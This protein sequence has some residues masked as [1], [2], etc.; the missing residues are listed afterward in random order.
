[1][2]LNIIR[3]M[4][5]KITMKLSPPTPSIKIAIIKKTKK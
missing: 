5:I 4:Q 3:D 1:M 2:I